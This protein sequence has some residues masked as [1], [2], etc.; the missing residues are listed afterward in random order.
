MR[1]GSENSF[2]TRSM[3]VLDPDQNLRICPRSFP[4]PPL[5]WPRDATRIESSS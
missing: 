5:Y 2:F 3:V 1:I 4:R